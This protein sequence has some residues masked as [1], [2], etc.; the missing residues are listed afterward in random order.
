MGFDTISRENGEKAKGFRLQK[1][2]AA[3]LMLET[4][5]KRPKA[6]FY[7]AIEVVEDVF[8]TTYDNTG[9]EKNY[10]EDKNYDADSN[11]T[12]FSPEV[13]NTL[14]S[15]FDIYISHWQSS[16]SVILGFYTTAS[17]GKERKKSLDDGTQLTLPAE[18]VLQVLSS[19]NVYSIDICTLVQQILIEEYSRQYCGKKSSG[20]LETLKKCS[21]DE[22]QKFLSKIAWRFGQ[23]DEVALK[24]RVLSLIKN[25]RLHN[26]KVANKEEIIWSLISEALDERQNQ[27]DF[28]QRF[29]F[30]SEIEMIFKRA[31]SEEIKDVLDPTWQIIQQLQAGITDKRN[32]SEKILAICPN[33]DS[34][35][36][37]LAARRAVAA[38]IEQANSDK[39][40]LALKYR[41]LEACENYLCDLAIADSIS[42]KEFEKI[43]DELRDLADTNLLELKKDYKYSVSNKI[44]IANIIMDLMDSC[45]ISLDRVH[46]A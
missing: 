37:K 32:L 17:I 43:V 9:V 29:V 38:K 31:E 3:N 40:F 19:T 11:F 14:V 34:K 41:V 20:N 21:A 30:S 46:H 26:F 27:K 45:F 1:L 25:S 42:D 16:E 15:F 12:I 22:F 5:Q 35:R 24:E 23:E 28:V 8:L 2:R 39:S 4:L 13:V 33:Y 18:P 44:T 36:M 7:A 10:E 6:M